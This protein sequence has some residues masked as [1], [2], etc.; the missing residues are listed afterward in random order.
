MSWTCPKCE[1]EL[2]KESQWHHCVKISLDTLFDGLDN[3]LLLVFDKILSEVADWDSVIISTT[4]NCI[5]FVHHQTFLVIRPMKKVLDIKFYSEN[6]L[7][8]NL[9][10]KSAVYSGK[11]ENHCRIS[12]IEQTTPQLFCYIKDSYKM[13]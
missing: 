2:V 11:N 8:D 13:L 5:V 12:N 9:I 3:E 6:T 10:S 1:R 4:K 7:H